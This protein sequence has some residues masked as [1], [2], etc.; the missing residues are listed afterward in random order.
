MRETDWKK[1]LRQDLERYGS[2]L[3]LHG[4][5]MQASGWPD[6]YMANKIWIG[7]IELKGPATKIE[8]LQRIVGR[9]LQRHG[10]FVIVRA[11]PTWEG[12][13]VSDADEHLT[14]VK[15]EDPTNA[16][17]ILHAVKR[18]VQDPE[19]GGKLLVQGRG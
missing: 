12:F 19:L 1:T 14:L 10:Q 13:T 18:F 2:A 8:T 5:M 11:S 4:N 15:E 16:W 6:L 7:W 3:S 9:Q 17:M